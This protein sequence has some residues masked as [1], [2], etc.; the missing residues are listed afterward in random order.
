M[1]TATPNPHAAHTLLSLVA[2]LAIAAGSVAAA[3]SLSLDTAV[4]A[5]GQ[6]TNLALRLTGAQASYGGF[7]AAV[8]IPQHV[9]LG[10]VATGPLLTTN[11]SLYA[12]PFQ[13]GTTG[14]VALAAFSA[15]ATF[16]ADGVLCRFALAAGPDAPPGAYPLTF[17][18]PAAAPVSSHAAHAL[19]TA[20][21]AQSVAHETQEGLL[22]IRY[23][24]GPGDT[25]G[26]GVPDAWEVVHFGVITNVSNTTDADRDGLSD[27]YEYKA[28]TDPRDPG[29]CIAIHATE[30]P[31][32]GGF[33]LRWYSVAGARYAIERS[34]DLQAT[35]SFDRI[36]HGLTATPPINVYTDRP[37]ADAALFYRIRREP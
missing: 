3:P 5:P 26:N 8:L 10:E 23:P 27:Y 22:T 15:T 31:A 13:L 7:N 2:A 1:K 37:P 19:S 28:G 24:G 17:G 6:T 25:N 29:S 21:G 12:A 32:P 18:F 14:G 30:T 16:S 11:F 9:T 20:N 35:G 34:P 33:V 4:L 36:G